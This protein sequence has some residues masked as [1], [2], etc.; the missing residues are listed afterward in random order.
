MAKDPVWGMEV[1]EPEAAP[2][3]EHMGTTCYIRSPGCKETF[4]KN[5]GQYAMGHGGH[6]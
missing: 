1:T 6:H 4:E 2:N 5:P 3:V